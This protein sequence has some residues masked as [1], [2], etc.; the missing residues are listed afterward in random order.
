[1]SAAD[2]RA[3]S[4][5]RVFL[6]ALVASLCV[7]AAVAIGT[8]LFAEF[9]DTAGRILATTALLS[10]A[11]LLSLPAGVLLDQRRAVPLAWGTIAAAGAGFVLAMVVI[12]AEREAEWLSRTTWTLWLGAGAG[13]QASVV[14]AMLRAG[15]S[16]RLR[17]LHAVSILL[18]SSLAALIAVAIWT[19]P[20]SDAFARA[21]GA[22]A[23]AAVL[24]SLLQ[25]ILQRIERPIAGRARL[26]L[27][28]DREPS[29]EAV[30]AAVEALGA[31]GVRVEKVV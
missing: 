30:A 26:V 5:R 6:W 23:I 9:D 19:E 3:G 12:W 13:A 29:E 27:D 4:G 1:M 2:P 21:L 24:T 18:A 11:C 14:T 7:T 28:L 25:P 16:R 17:V 20:D 15:A 10:L 8:L 31:H 22:L